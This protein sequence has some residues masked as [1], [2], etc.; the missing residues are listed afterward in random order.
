MSDSIIKT[1]AKIFGGSAIAGMGFAFGR[2]VYNKI[3]KNRGRLLI[4]FFLLCP[5]VG[6]VAGGLWLARNHSGLFKSIGMRILALLVLIPSAFIL[7]LCNIVAFEVLNHNPKQANLEITTQRPITEEDFTTAPKAIVVE[8]NPENDF[9]SIHKSEG[10]KSVPATNQNQFLRIQNYGLPG[11]FVGLGLIKGFSQRG[12]RKRVWE[13]ERFN[14]DFML[15]HGLKEL[16]DGTI[17]D[18]QNTQIYRVDHCGSDRVTL[19]PL[20]KRGKRAYI[21][22][23][24]VGKYYEF[25]GVI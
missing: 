9:E 10:N 8:P 22:I 13:A 2:D 6:A 24:N 25:T 5:F 3:K 15:K 11:F 20:G 12:R 16:E 23:D 4:T 1:S 21:K 7:L 17:E 19:F 14:M 18:V